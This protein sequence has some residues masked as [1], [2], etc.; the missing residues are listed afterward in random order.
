MFCKKSTVQNRLEAN[1]GELMRMHGD[2][3][4]RLGCGECV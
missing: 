4:V 1:T 2:A 3:A